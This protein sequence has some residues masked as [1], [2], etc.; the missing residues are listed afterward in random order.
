MPADTPDTTPDAGV[1]LATVGSVLLHEPPGVMSVKLTVAP[2][3][4]LAGPP[5]AAGV[6][7]TVR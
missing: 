5:M 2:T 1:I 3:Q 7:L 6:A 4:T